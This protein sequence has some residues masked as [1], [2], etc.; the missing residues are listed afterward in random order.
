MGGAGRRASAPRRRG[1]WGRRRARR[2]ALFWCGVRPP[3]ACPT[4]A[5]PPA[6]VAP[7]CVCY[8]RH[9][10]RS[11]WWAGRPGPGWLPPGVAEGARGESERA[12]EAR[13]SARAAW[14]LSPRA[15]ARALLP[16][17]ATRGAS[18]AR[19]HTLLPSPSLTQRAMEAADFF[20]EYG[21]ANRYVIKEIIGEKKK[22]RGDERER[23]SPRDKR[24]ESGPPAPPPHARLTTHHHHHLSLSLS[25][26]LS[27]PQARAPTASSVPPWTP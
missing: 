11:G 4:T 6:P 21:E 20:T 19:T 27:S 24:Q 3:V 13:F 26:S 10:S 7:S 16:G 14:P 2:A 8:T 17:P 15:R 5:P 18:A 25:F 1:A 9:P 12:R 23:E 22:E